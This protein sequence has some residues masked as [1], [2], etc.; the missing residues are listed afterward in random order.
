MGN[1]EQT[2]DAGVLG[3]AKESPMNG[4][5]WSITCNHP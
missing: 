5:P 1:R 3:D 4:G 2:V